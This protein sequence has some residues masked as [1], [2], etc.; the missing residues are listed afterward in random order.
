MIGEFKDEK[1][2]RDIPQKIIKAVKKTL[3]HPEVQDKRVK[4]ASECAYKL[5]GWVN[6][7]LNTN[8]ALLVV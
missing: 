5:F 7:I 3:E 6:A 4:G 8:A 1:K 2:V